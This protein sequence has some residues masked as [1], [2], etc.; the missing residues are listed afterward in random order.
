M[1][2]EKFLCNFDFIEYVVVQVLV[3]VDTGIL[4]IGKYRLFLF[5]FIL[6][7]YRT[8]NSISPCTKDPQELTT[9]LNNENIFTT[10]FAHIDYI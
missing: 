2:T 6:L 3:S 8:Y 9:V 4:G 10:N 5:S 7:N 1:I